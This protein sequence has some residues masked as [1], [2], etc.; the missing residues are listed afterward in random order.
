M[1]RHNRL[2]AQHFDKCAALLSSPQLLG[3]DLRDLLLFRGATN[4]AVGGKADVEREFLRPTVLQPALF[5]VEYALAMTYIESGVTPVA[6]AGHSIGEYVAATIS[7]ILPLSSALGLVYARA[8]GTEYGHVDDSMRGTML[9]VRLSEAHVRAYVES[10]QNQARGSN[11]DRTDQL[12]MDVAVF[13]AAVN[14]PVHTVLSGSENAIAAAEKELLG[15]AAETAS[16]ACNF[17]G[18]DPSTGAAIRCVRLHVTNAFHSPLM[19]AAGRTIE[20]YL[21]ALSDRDNVN[22]SSVPQIPMTSNVTGGWLHDEANLQDCDTSTLY[23]TRHLLGTVRWLENVK[24]FLRWEPDVVLEVGPGNTLSTLVRKCL[25]SDTAEAAKQPL[26]VQSMARAVDV[27][28]GTSDDESAFAAALGKLWEA[29]VDVAWDVWRNQDLVNLGP[30]ARCPARLPRYCWERTRIW[31]N[32][33]ASIYAPLEDE[34]AHVEFVED[35]NDAIDL[36]TAQQPHPCLVRFCEDEAQSSASKAVLYCFPYAGGSSRMFEDWTHTVT[37]AHVPAWL[38]IVAIE[39]RGRGA[40]ADDDV[41]EGGDEDA[42]TKQDIEELQILARAIH[43]DAS[44]RQIFFCGFSFGALIAAEVAAL[45]DS[46]NE[47]SSAVSFLAI[48]GRAPPFVTRGLGATN[49][50]STADIEAFNLAPPLSTRL[51]GMEHVF[52]SQCCYEIC[53][54]TGAHHGA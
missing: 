1:Y 46:A 35:D 27:K 7:Q 21:G 19:E 26:V 50:V 4:P 47:H 41:Q 34:D 42:R 40:R 25:S 5:S 3:R 2:F 39:L 51:R 16:D 48:V 45:I 15:K 18:I 49:D 10:K 53:V 30:A 6:V 23:W 33:S 29:G 8:S 43:D 24:S 20:T 54:Q 22:A 36:P 11:S 17:G 14:S 13:L 12:D 37:G 44:G 38:D 9:S 32:P 52:L 28:Q 31:Q